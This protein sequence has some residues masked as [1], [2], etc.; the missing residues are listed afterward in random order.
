M[1]P[2]SPDGWQ[3]LT[4]SCGQERYAKLVHLRWRAGAGITEEP[5]GYFCL[6]CHATVNSGALI[7][8]AQMKAKRQELRDLEAEVIE[9]VPPKVAVKK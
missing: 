1:E 6:E 4:C 7:A 5:A 8:Q 3:R 9:T 2:K